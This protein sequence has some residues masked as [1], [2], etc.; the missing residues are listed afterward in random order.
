MK[1]TIRASSVARIL[2]CSHS[3]Y[4]PKDDMNSVYAQAGTDQHKLAQQFLKDCIMMEFLR[5]YEALDKDSHTVISLS[6]NENTRKY[7]LEIL[8]TYHKLKGELISFGVEQSFSSDFK[9]FNLTGTPDFYFFTRRELIVFDLKNGYQAIDPNCAQLKTYAIL[10][11]K[12]LRSKIYPSYNDICFPTSLV[13]VQNEE[14]KT[15]ELYLQDESQVRGRGG[16]LIDFQNKIIDAMNNHTFKMGKECRYCP[17]KRHCLLV[18]NDLKT[19]QKDSTIIEDKEMLNLLEHQSILVSA[20]DEM[21]GYSVKFHPEWWDTKT[22][23]YKQWID[24]SKAP[25]VLKT[26]TPAAA[27]R[28]KFDVV[29]NIKE[30]LRISYVLKKEK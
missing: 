19:L 25:Q 26:M 16:D 6:I 17:S 23:R 1:R 3:T 8:N 27:L 13:I 28:E 5:A 9:N 12:N 2:Q 4:L 10:I 14:V 18:R 24:E 21:K 7:L 20:L 15:H 30:E 29:D 22:R 11:C